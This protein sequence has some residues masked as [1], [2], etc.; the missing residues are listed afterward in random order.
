M[1]RPP[2]TLTVYDD[3]A[4]FQREAAPFLL[5]NEA[6][7]TLPIGLLH[8]LIQ[9]PAA[10]DAPFLATVHDDATI[11]GAFVRTPPYRLIVSAGT[12]FTALPPLVAHLAT[13]P[14]A[15]PGVTGPVP[16]ASAFATAW[17]AETGIPAQ[18]SRRLRIY[19]LTEVISPPLPAG[20]LRQATATDREQLIEWFLAFQAEIEPAH[21]TSRERIA[22]LIDS[23]LASAETPIWFW[24]VAGQPVTLVG[25]SGATPHSRR[26]APVYTPPA[27]R[28]RGYASAAT[29]AVSQL[30][31]DSGIQLVV[32]FTDLANPTANHIY[33]AI[34]YRPLLDTVDFDFMPDE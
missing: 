6:T 8:A 34:G 13:A 16:L 10:H 25:I 31:L 18:E 17:T 30:L 15:V 28:R 12:Q 32:L 19:G 29:A 14:A 9:A 11:T 21:A 7:N 24:D 22:P 3:A 5:A 20:A 1:S 27:F 2:L 4:T 23:R 33:Q 26:I